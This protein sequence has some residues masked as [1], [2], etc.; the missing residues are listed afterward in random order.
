MTEAAIGQRLTFEAY[1][2]HDDGTDTHYELVAG[3]LVALPLESRLNSQISVFLALELAKLMPSDHICHKDTEIEVTGA[4]AQ[5]RLPDLMVLSEELAAM[6]GNRRGTITRDMPPPVLVVEVVS[7][8]KANEERD[9]RYKRSE[10][11][12]RG[13]S[14]YWII[15]PQQAKVS[16]LTLVAGLYEAEEYTGDAIVQSQ[17]AA[18]TLTAEQVLRSHP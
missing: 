1:L 5:V 6:L 14:K 17:F 2:N 13:I 8:G 4:K 10:Y 16:V 7:P 3:E 12:A 18:L 11:A 15:D 9:Y